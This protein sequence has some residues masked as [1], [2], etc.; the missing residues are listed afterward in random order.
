VSLTNPNTHGIAAIAKPL[1]TESNVQM[2][3]QRCPITTLKPGHQATGNMRVIWSDESFFMLFPISYVWRT[4]NEAY[5]L[6]CPVPTVKQRGVCGMVW[7]AISWYSIGPII[8][9]H[10]QITAR[11]YMDR[12]GNQEHSMIQTL[13][14]NNVVFQNDN[15]LIQTAGNV[16]LWFEEYEG[17]LQYLLWPAQSPHLNS[18]EPL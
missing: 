6:E 3:K 12:L 18:T 11:E 2:R 5:N 10:G 16:Q 13:P 4:P 9:L 14:N 17:K 8:T 1:I 15:A 7:A